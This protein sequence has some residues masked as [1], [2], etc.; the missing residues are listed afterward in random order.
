M[1]SSPS[2]YT[3][4]RSSDSCSRTNKTNAEACVECLLRLHH[5]SHMLDNLQP[6]APGRAAL[7]TNLPCRSGR[8]VLG[9]LLLCRCQS[10]PASWPCQRKQGGGET[11]KVGAGRRQL[12]AHIQAG[13][14]CRKHANKLARDRTACPAVCPRRLLSIVCLSAS[15]CLSSIAPRR[16]HLTSA[17]KL[18]PPLTSRQLRAGPCLGV[19]VSV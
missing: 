15:A 5:P 6:P 12:V 11:V 17:L 14:Q 4:T 3:C 7:Q 19:S 18:L 16:T 8:A 10:G 2:G 1:L 13:G 9:P